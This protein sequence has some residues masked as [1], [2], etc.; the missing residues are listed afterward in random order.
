MNFPKLSLKRFLVAAAV[1]LAI[2]MVVVAGPKLMRDAA[3]ECAGPERH[4]MPGGELPPPYLPALNLDEAQR[5]KVFAILHEQAPTQRE[6]LKRL[7]RAQADLRRLTAGPDYDETKARALAE[8]IGRAMSEVALLRARTDRLI[9]DLLSPEQRQRQ[10]EL[11]P[12]GARGIPGAA[13][14]GP[15]SDGPARPPR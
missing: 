8:Q 7:N 4:G 1:S 12:E 6:R 15:G 14:R 2:P 11:G 5:D 13:P 9:F 10:A 3:S